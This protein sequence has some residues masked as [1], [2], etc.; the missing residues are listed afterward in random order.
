MQSCS[1]EIKLDSNFEKLKE[2][3]Q[4]DIYWI[5][6]F[7]RPCCP[8]PDFDGAVKMLDRLNA[9][10]QSCPDYSDEEKSQLA[11]LIEARKEWYPHSGLCRR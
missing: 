10:A 7:C 1:T 4:T 11:Q 6:F 5:R 3:M 2:E 9:E 8:A